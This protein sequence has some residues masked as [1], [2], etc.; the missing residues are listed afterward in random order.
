M[1]YGDKK[2]IKYG[3]KKKLNIYCAVTNTWRWP[4]TC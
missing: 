2:K 4:V 1:K 3:D